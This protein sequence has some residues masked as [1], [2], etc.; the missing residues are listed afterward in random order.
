MT[1]VGRQWMLLPEGDAAVDAHL[2]GWQGQ[3]VSAG[4]GGAAPGPE[5][6]SAYRVDPETEALAAAL[7]V[8]MHTPTDAILTVGPEEKPP[9]L[10]LSWGKGLRSTFMAVDAFLDA[11]K[12]GEYVRP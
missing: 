3:V 10:K 9:G 5:P 7:G 8:W 1:E 4:A 2:A 12:A 6:G 11:V